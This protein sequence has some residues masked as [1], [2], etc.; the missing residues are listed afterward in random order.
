MSGFLIGYFGNHFD[1]KA[2]G[3]KSFCMAF[4]ARTKLKIKSR[5]N[6]SRAQFLHQFLVNEFFSA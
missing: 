5:H 2:S 4:A 1:I 6:V 3:E